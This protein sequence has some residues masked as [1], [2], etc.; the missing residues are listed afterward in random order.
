MNA[1]PNLQSFFQDLLLSDTKKIK[2]IPLC[3]PY[4]MGKLSSL[5]LST[6]FTDEGREKQAQECKYHIKGLQN[7]R[8]LL[9]KQAERKVAQVLHRLQG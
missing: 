3:S 9:E 6:D 2:K 7:V 4:A 5:Q 1:T 8:L